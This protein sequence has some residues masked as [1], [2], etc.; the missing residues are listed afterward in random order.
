MAW[1]AK[2][3]AYGVVCN[4]DGAVGAESQRTGLRSVEVKTEV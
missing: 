3:P 1:S 2:R 4:S